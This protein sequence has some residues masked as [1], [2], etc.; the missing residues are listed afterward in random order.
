MF[1]VFG[2]VQACL[3][4]DSLRERKKKLLEGCL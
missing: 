3:C 1:T 4:Q 2:P